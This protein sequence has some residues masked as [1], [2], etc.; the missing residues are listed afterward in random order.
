MMHFG[1][2]DLPVYPADTE[3][4]S[5]SD[6]YIDAVESGKTSFMRAV[7]IMAPTMDS[8]RDCLETNESELMRL[9]DLCKSEVVDHEWGF[10][11][12]KDQ[13]IVPNTMPRFSYE[14]LPANHLLVAKVAV[15][16]PVI[17]PGSL[18]VMTQRFELILRGIKRYHQEQRL[19]KLF[20]ARVDQFSI[21]INR[22]RLANP[23]LAWFL[24]I[25]PRLIK[26]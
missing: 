11:D 16:E 5:S 9:A 18:G 23:N 7:G 17:E 15:I 21:G 8:L 6:Q 10:F 1:G 2:L 13:Q 24:D 3:V 14:L 4:L 22:A 20:D 26:T 25:E 12:N 19:Y